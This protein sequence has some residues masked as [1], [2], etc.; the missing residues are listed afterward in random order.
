MTPERWWNRVRMRLR[1][2]LRRGRVER[3]LD[4]ELRFHL[5]RQIEENQAAGM[6]AAEARYAALRRL[7]GVAQIQEECREMRRTNY[8]DNLVQDLRYAARTL[9]KSPAL[10]AAIILTLGLAIGANSAIFS[11]IDGV[12][13]RPLPY[14]QPDRIVR[15]FFSSDHY[16][17]FPINPFDFRDFRTRSHSFEA[18]AAFTRGDVQ[19]SGSGDPVRLAA[20]RVTAG[21]FRALGVAPER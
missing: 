15:L 10:A 14:R 17:K 5:G 8:V 16:P 4:R 6:S 12:L 9:A 13:L 2:V 19:L 20:F 21:Y 18:L 3:E 11:V 1:S 7:G